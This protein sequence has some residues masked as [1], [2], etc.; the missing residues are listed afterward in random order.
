MKFKHNQPRQKISG[1][2]V[3]MSVGSSLPLS[4]VEDEY[5]WEFLYC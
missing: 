2:I 5:F 3:K 1:L 4:F